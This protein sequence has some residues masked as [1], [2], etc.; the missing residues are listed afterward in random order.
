MS[1]RLLHASVLLALTITPSLALAQAPR[2][3][4]R[5]EGSV[6]RFETEGDEVV[7]QASARFSSVTS[8][9]DLDPGDVPHATGSLEV[10]MDSVTTDDSAWDAM[11]R[12]APFLALDEFPR[13]SFTLTSIEGPAAVEDGHWT[14]VTLV[15]D[16]TV[17]GVA[18]PR[19]IPAR[20][21]W[22][23]GDGHPIVEVRADFHFRWEEHRINVPTGL[24][25]SFA[26]DGAAVHVELVFQPAGRRPPA[27]R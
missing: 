5:P 17:H 27:R 10:V 9:L 21:R 14:R 25:R 12:H 26:G 13:A 8:R 2:W 24:T 1:E 6:V 19:R 11:F 7:E 18:R 3:A 16:F 15:G 4:L 20:L 23:S 22:R